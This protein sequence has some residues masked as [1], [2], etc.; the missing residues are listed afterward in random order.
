VTVDPPLS[1]PPLSDP[2]V[3]AAGTGQDAAAGAGPLLLEEEFGGGPLY[4]L[5][6][7]VA[8]HAS[9]AGMS[10]Q[11]AIDVTIVVQELAANAVRH[12][13]GRGRLRMWSQD[14]ALVCRVEDAGPEPRL[15][16]AAV[17]GAGG[18]TSAGWP[19][20]HGHGLWL[21]RQ[22]AD[23]MSVVSGPGGTCAT[24]VFALG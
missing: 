10:G 16:R 24:V 13:A 8:A 5:R 14:G 3:L 19:Y 17:G 4:S 11:R 1:D 20:P 23:E 21:A 6:Q 15:G 7:A 2:P 9:A 18:S 12:G 22:V